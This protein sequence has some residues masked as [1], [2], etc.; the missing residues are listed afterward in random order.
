MPTGGITDSDDPPSTYAI[1]VVIYQV[2][3]AV[4]EDC[5]WWGLGSS[6]WLCMASYQPFTL[7]LLVVKPAAQTKV[8][9]TKLHINCFRNP[10]STCARENWKTE[11]GEATNGWLLPLIKPL[12]R[13][14]V[15]RSVGKFNIRS[16][17]GKKHLANCYVLHLDNSNSNV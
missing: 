14:G 13:S 8:G 4:H 5:Q 9:K 15:K 6:D 16:W 11:L 1:V 7:L 3:A 2:T 17:V 10:T 12:Q